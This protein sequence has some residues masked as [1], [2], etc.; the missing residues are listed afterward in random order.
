MDSL[1]HRLKSLG[2]KLGANDVQ[3]PKPHKEGYPVEDVVSGRLHRTI[4]GEAFWVESLYAKDYTHGH[5]PLQIRHPLHILTEWAQV[6]QVAQADLRHFVFLDT[7]TTGLSGGTGTLVFMVG[8]GRF[9]DDGFQVAQYFLR[10]PAEEIAVLAA[11]SEY[12]DPCEAV[13]TFNGRA[14]DIPLLTT[15]YTL[16]ALSF[17]LVGTPHLDLLPLARR[18]WRDRLPSRRLGYL[19]STILGAARTPALRD[20]TTGVRPGFDR[21]QSGGPL[22]VAT[23]VQGPHTAEV[24]ADALEEFTRHAADDGGVAIVGSAEPAGD[25]SADVL[26]RLEQDEEA[27]G[28]VGSRGRLRQGRSAG[29][30][31]GFHRCSSPAPLPAA[32]S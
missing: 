23:A 5:S 28:A 30:H 25:H 17:P 10:E 12:L 32:S 1:S 24:L 8:L 31:G 19:E 9:T 4:Y 11:V 2:V 14:F 18:L 26:P 7:E 29:S 22:A 16:Q 20:Y 15:R 27:D 13:V 21:R 3:P 6:P